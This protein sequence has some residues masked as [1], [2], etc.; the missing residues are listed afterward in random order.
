MTALWLES[1]AAAFEPPQDDVFLKL[2]FR[3]NEGPQTRFLNLPDENIDVL[4]GGAAGGSKSTSL[5]MYALRACI[6]FPGLQAFWIRRSF[7]ELEHSVLRMLARYG[8]AKS[9][10]CTW[11]ADKHELRFPGGSVLTFAHA[12]NIQEASAFLSAEVN[13]LLIDERT[14]LIPDVVDMLYTRVRSGVAGVPCL[15]VRS[16]TNPGEVGHSRVLSEFVEAT[17]HG[18]FEITDAN[19][20]RRIFI[21]A[22]ATDTPQLGAEYIRNLSGLPEKLRKAYLEGDWTVF[23]GQVFDSWRY[24]RHVMQPFAL[25][26]TWVRY[27]GIDWGF[28]AAWCALTAAVDEDGR[29]WVYRELYGQRVGEADQAKSILASE[30]P[31]ETVAA[32]FGDDAMWA[33]RG[34]AKPISDVF[35]EHGVHLTQAGKG[36]GSRITRVQRTRSYLAD[37]PACSHHRALGHDT[38]AMMHVFPACENLIRTLPTLPHAKTGNPE[39]VDTNAEDHAYDALSYML[40]NLGTGPEFLS[41][42]DDGPGMDGQFEVLQPAGIFAVR[43]QDDAPAW[44]DDE[45]PRGGTTQTWP[46]SA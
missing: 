29:V 6:R 36:P 19:Q 24:D 43:P 10:G 23:A 4:Y 22:R 3:P 46:P 8:F 12:K 27:Q 41:P 39:D 40:I 37:G 28:A 21:Q 38:C 30:A 26:P 2:G 18:E 31:G 1:A 7:P 44:D 35:S 32:R 20:R 17:G 42:Y 45:R 34:D 15:G 16:A 5:F 14:T 11:R 13:L 9:L 25:P 33:T